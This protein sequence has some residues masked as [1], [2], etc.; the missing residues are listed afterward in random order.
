ML[1]AIFVGLNANHPC[2]GSAEQWKSV[3][4]EDELQIEGR[5]VKQRCDGSLELLDHH[6]LISS[7]HDSDTIEGLLVTRASR[8]TVRFQKLKLI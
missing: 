7:D 6:R 5:N 1:C 2:T 3:I 8:R 4:E